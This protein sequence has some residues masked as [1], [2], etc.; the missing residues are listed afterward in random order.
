M[1][2]ALHLTQIQIGWLNTTFPSRIR[3]SKFPAVRWASCSAPGAPTWPSAPSVWLPPALSPLYSGPVL[4][5]AMLAAQILLGIA[6]GPFF[7]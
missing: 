1:M 5:V 3:S 6:L 7:R 2:P 4:F